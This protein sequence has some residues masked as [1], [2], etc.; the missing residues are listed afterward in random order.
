M[1]GTV[2]SNEVV[3]AVVVLA[4]DDERHCTLRFFVG[5]FPSFLFPASSFPFPAHTA[6]SYDRFSDVVHARRRYLE[7]E[8]STCESV[9]QS[10]SQSINQSVSQPVGYYIYDIYMA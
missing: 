7:G 5:P 8:G 3:V 1:V 4:G 2:S 10:V 6:L 9:S